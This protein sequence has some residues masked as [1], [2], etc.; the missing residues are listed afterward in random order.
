MH[1]MFIYNYVYIYIYIYV[2]LCISG[3]GAIHWIPNKKMFFDSL[4]AGSE[5]H[6]DPAVTT[7]AVSQGA[8]KSKENYS[9]TALEK[10]QMI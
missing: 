1:N 2:Y 9:G 7:L 10:N 8:T 5:F 4:S 3:K 6:T